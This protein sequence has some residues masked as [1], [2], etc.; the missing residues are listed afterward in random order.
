MIGKED[1]NL[2]AYI[3]ENAEET[4]VVLANFYGD[5][6]ARP[7]IE[8]INGRQAVCANYADEADVLRP[9]EARMYVIGK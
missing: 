8:V 6:I 3:R 4:M 2:F 9:Y 1:P 5:T 7:A